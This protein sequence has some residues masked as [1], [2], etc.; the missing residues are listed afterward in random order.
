MILADF[1]A[2]T[3]EPFNFAHYFDIAI[4]QAFFC[5]ITPDLRE[6]YVRQMQG[7]L[8]PQGKLV[9][10]LW[11]CYFPHECQQPPEVKPPF[12][13]NVEEYKALFADK[14]NINIMQ[15][16]HNSHPARQGRELFV[17]LEN[18]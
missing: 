9:G 2:L 1:F 15:A 10:V 13:G 3:N 5:A 7:L 16:C 8:K 6:K 18:T 12:G 14:L 4:E 11:D 17:E